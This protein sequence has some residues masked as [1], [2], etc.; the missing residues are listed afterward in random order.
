MKKSKD[1][2]KEDKTSLHKRYLFWLYKMTREES[3]K[4]DRKFTQLD[5]DKEIQKLLGDKVRGLGAAFEKNLSPFLKEWKKY[6]FQKESDAQKLKF[7][8]DGLMD[9]GY[10]FLRLKLEAIEQVTKARFGRKALAEFK[11]LYEEISLKRIL[12]DT[13]GRR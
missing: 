10:L 2:S 4:T 7:T 9:P 11:K 3:D 13:S 12:E 8:E 1:I 5:V 6:V